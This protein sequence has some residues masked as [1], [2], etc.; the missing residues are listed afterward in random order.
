MNYPLVKYRILCIFIVTFV[1]NIISRLTSDIKL[2]RLRKM[3]STVQK[4]SFLRSKKWLSHRSISLSAKKFD[5]IESLK[6]FDFSSY[7][8]V[9]IFNI[10]LSFIQS[11]FFV[12]SFGRSFIGGLA[13]CA[14][15]HRVVQ[16]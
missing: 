12:P 10:L 4:Y 14:R 11:L 16:S 5:S 13:A 2:L 3:G 15:Q 8:S 7:F 9:N 1:K 6:L